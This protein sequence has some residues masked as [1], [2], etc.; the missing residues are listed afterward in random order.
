[1]IREIPEAALDIVAKFEGCE[2]TAYRDIVGV[3]TIGYGSTGPHVK[4]GMKITKS[5]ARNL[6]RAD[7]KIAAQRVNAKIPGVVNDLTDNQ[8]AALLSF[9]FN[10]G[11]GNPAKPEWTIW[12]R[13]RARQF[14]QI[15]LEF[16]K[17]VNAGGKKVK[18]LVNRRTAEVQL[19]STDEPG[20]TEESLPSSVTREVMTPPTVQDPTPL[21]KSGTLITVATGAVAAVPVAVQQVAAAVEPYAQQ[22]AMIQQILGALAMVAAGAA[23][24]GLVLAWLNKK[25]N[26]T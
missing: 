9:V 3:L 11:S 4:P 20:S 14:E 16:M 17:F 15:P 8:Y 12:K 5:E 24:L 1:M 18:G 6:L 19:W 13:L 10:L 22:N 23:V 2:L 25:R 7:M 21:H 26:Q